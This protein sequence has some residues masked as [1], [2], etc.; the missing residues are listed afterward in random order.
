MRRINARSPLQSFGIWML[1]PALLEFA[2]EEQKRHYLPQIARGEIRWCQ[3]YSEPNYGSDLAGLQTRADDKGDYYPGQW[4]QDLDLICRHG[5]LDFL[6]G[7]YRYRR[8][9]ARRY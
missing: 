9:K 7:A 8:A 1:G 3:G 5:R 2:S 6:P 4:R